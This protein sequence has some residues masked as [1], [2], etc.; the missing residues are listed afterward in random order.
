MTCTTHWIGRVWPST[1]GDAISLFTVIAI[2]NGP[3]H[4]RCCM[5]QNSA[6]TNIVTAAG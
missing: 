3:P 5:K 6:H 1:E 2:G 4:G